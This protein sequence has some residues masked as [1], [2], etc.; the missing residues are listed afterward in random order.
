MTKPKQPK[1]VVQKD[2]VSFRLSDEAER[3][4]LWQYAQSIENYDGKSVS[5]SKAAKKIVLDFL[6]ARFKKK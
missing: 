5:P 6:Q 2:I 1:G 4:L 3:A